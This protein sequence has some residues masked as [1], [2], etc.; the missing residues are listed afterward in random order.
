MIARGYSDVASRL[1]VVGGI[2]EAAG[3]GMN[4]RQRRAAKAKQRAKERLA[5]HTERGFAGAGAWGPAP[6]D[7][8][9]EIAVALVRWLGHVGADPA[10]ADAAAADLLDRSPAQ[11][12]LLAVVVAEAL[13]SLVAPLT[14]G[15]WTPND[16][17]QLLRRRLGGSAPA[18]V[19]GPLR[20]QGARVGAD[21]VDDQWQG[22]LAE[23]PPAVEPDL[24]TT[25]G[26]ALSLRVIA[27]LRDLPRIAVTVPA[28]GNW[29]L[30]RTAAAPGADA[31]RQLA[32]VR[33]LLAK[34]ESTTYEA[35]A[36][37]LTA[38]AQEL[39]TRH[40][41]ERLLARIDAPEPS[42][43]VTTRRIW[44]DAPYVMAKALLVDAVAAAN[45]CRTVISEALG[46]TSLVGDPADLDDVEMLATS[47]LVQ[48][49]AAMLR[50]GR[51]ANRAGM[52]RTRAFRQSFLLSYATRIGERLRAAGETALADVDP[53][54][55]LPVLRSVREDVDREFAR[56]FPDTV[57]K[58]SRVSDAHGWAAGRAAADL[59]RL[60]VHD[61]VAG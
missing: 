16:L 12:R 20:R 46:F 45:R 6:G 21:R 5:H 11:R 60:D 48:A 59:A 31:A 44:I 7:D 54:R 23:L 26:L 25:G 43:G 28:P 32:K 56:V 29:R 39:I 8:R 4:N 57:A 9:Q 49:D 19:A 24:T 41:L 17:R 52:S 27:L 3:M 38:K 10:V 47:L 2:R 42:S 40:A 14:A 33:A 35:E 22:E 18:L 50:H 37:A 58:V 36:D 13:E 1:A 61:Q 30:A 34:A 55:L 53:E 51:Q 15:G